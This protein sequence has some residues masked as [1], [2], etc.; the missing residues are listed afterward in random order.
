MRESEIKTLIS[1]GEGLRIEFKQCKTALSKEVYETV[2]AFLNR[3]GGELL[4]GISDDGEVVGIDPE[5]IDQVKKDFTASINNPQKISPAFYL[6]M[7]E[8]VINGKAIL[9]IYVP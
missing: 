5:Y 9:Y 7:D 6:T 3:L 2:C 8:I 4:L 1:Q